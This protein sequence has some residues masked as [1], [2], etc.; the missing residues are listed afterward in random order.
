MGSLRIKIIGNGG[1]L[2]RGLAY[3]SFL[4]GTRFLAEAPPDIMASLQTRG[5]DLDAIDTVYLSHLHGDH[6]FG[7][8]FL[9][10][11]KWVRELEELVPGRLTVLGPA[12]I[13]EHT[14]LL[15]EAAFTTSHPCYAW[16]LEKVTFHE[17]GVDFHWEVEGLELS[18]FALRH[19]METYGF[20][21][22][23]DGAPVFA[24]VADTRWG[25]AV[26]ALL[27]RQVPCVLM[28]MNGGGGNIHVSPA[29]ALEK[30]LPI[31]GEGTTYYGT[32]LGE[33]FAPPHPLIRCATPGLEIDL[34][35]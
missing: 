34:T 1:C 19:I 24:Y 32:H 23:R 16:L 8:P 13:A 11:N 35:F 21:L 12:G 15:T 25:R 9:I 22:S 3:N 18:C 14:R 5:A 30:A 6:A 29:E 7:L 31:T 27:R 33:E 20:L 28:D 4:V 26:E 10:I 2:N 17:I